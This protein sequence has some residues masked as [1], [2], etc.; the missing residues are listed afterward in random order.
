MEGI[1]SELNFDPGIAIPVAN[2]E[3]KALEFQA[4]RLCVNIYF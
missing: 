3:N 4:S 1:L 2:K